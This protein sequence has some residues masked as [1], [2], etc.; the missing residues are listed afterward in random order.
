MRSPRQ[1][2]LTLVAEKAAALLGAR[3]AVVALLEAD[4]ETL[5]FTAVAGELVSTL[6]GTR[7]QAGDTYLGQAA[8][9]G[10]P[11]LLYR[12]AMSLPERIEMPTSAAAVPIFADGLPIG[13]L[14]AINKEQNH[15]FTG[16]DLLTLSTLA[17]VLA[18]LLHNDRL[19]DESY[20]QRRELSLLYEAVR[21]V[22]GKLS[23][24]QALQTVVT[25]TAVHLDS[26]VVV[27][28]LVN[29]DRTHLYIAEEQGLSDDAREIT[30]ATYAGIGRT[31]MMA[32]RPVF[33]SF[34]TE[35]TDDAEFLPLQ[36]NPFPHLRIRSGIAAPIRSNGQIQ[37]AILVLSNLNDGYTLA[38]ANLLT[39]LASQTAVALENALLYED[40]N[41]RADEAVALT[42]LA[43]TVNSTLRLAQILQKVADATTRLLDTGT[44]A[45]FL[46]PKNSRR[47]ALEMQRGLTEG[48]EERLKINT[49]DG[50]PGW[51]VQHQ[52][53]AAVANLATDSRNASFPL[54][55]EGI[56]SLLCMPL[57]VGDSTIG[58]LCAGTAHRRI[59]TISEAE[60]LFTIA[61]HAALAIENARVYG[62]VRQKN[63]ELRRLFHRTAKMLGSAQ[64]PEHALG[65]VVRLTADA[66]E[67]ERAVLYEV[68]ENSGERTILN[69]I[70]AHGFKEGPI[71]PS[72]M[73]E[74]IL[75]HGKSL[76]IRNLLDDSRFMLPLEGDSEIR[77]RKNRRSMAYLGAPIRVNQRIV[78]ILEVYGRSRRDWRT[79]DMR[80]LLTFASQA[81]VAFHN[82]FLRRNAGDLVRLESAEQLLCTVRDHRDSLPAEIVDAVDAFF[83]TNALK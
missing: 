68:V 79:D 81:G 18:V 60:L 31:L 32:N 23:M 19:R 83:S 62:E 66:L 71:P 58:A 55:E 70:A 46:R 26:G 57:Q 25:Q 67:S 48:A 14:A 73:A 75:L 39:A 35:Q 15:P 21:A 77:P 16:D 72:P 53:P 52:S 44:V 7:A 22:S 61:T 65:L 59:F 8:R 38:D 13:T 11:A 69:G 30:F 29:D 74:W 12:R 2:L 20:R 1:E 3:T 6:R 47:L 37:G 49:G 33:L 82:R 56:T 51:V 10:E 5:H 54:E 41:R 17:A 45:L 64:S 42:E 80:L 36:E 24:R 50:I 28:L 9:T 27:V 63:R 76:R 78:G 40:A 34:E 4:R 43:Q